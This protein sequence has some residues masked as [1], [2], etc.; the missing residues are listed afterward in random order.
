MDL[1]EPIEPII[2][3]DELGQNDATILVRPA[4]VKGLMFR[5]SLFY[6][7]ETW[8]ALLH[9]DVKALL[10]AFVLEYAKPIASTSTTP[11]ESPVEVFKRIWIELGWTR[12]HALGIAEGPSRK[13]FA[14]SV[15]RGF[16]G[17]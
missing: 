3:T 4:Q 8:I 7:S 15:L 10:D 17:E 11:E 1:D 9:A 6:L 13:T 5:V 2:S 12:I 16:L 14:E